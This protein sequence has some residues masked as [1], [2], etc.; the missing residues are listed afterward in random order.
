MRTFETKAKSIQR[1]HRKS[2]SKEVGDILVRELKRHKR[3]RFAFG[4]F[5]LTKR[6]R[7]KLTV[8]SEEVI[9]VPHY[10]ISFKQSARLKRAIRNT[11]QKTI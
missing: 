6:K 3:V 1:E 5:T 8:E 11:K 7:N 10:Y 2:L 4:T 9:K